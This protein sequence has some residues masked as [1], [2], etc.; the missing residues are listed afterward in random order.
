MLRHALNV[1]SD[2]ITWSPFYSKHDGVCPARDCF[3]ESIQVPI[4]IMNQRDELSYYY[5]TTYSFITFSIN[6]TYSL[7]GKFQLYDLEKHVLV[8]YAKLSS[9]NYNIL[10]PLLEYGN[11]EHLQNVLHAHSIRNLRYILWTTGYTF[12]NLDINL[13]FTVLVKTKSVTLGKFLK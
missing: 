3:K 8:R 10:L 5:I 2:L 9:W 6:V 1:L 11:E 7:H 13:N 4:M 12:W